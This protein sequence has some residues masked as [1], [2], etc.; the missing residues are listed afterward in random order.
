MIDCFT[1]ESNRAVAEQEVGATAVVGS[2]TPGRAPVMLHFVSRRTP[3]ILRRIDTVV[4]WNNRRRVSSTAIE[5]VKT[6]PRA[7]VIVRIREDLTNKDGIGQ[8]VLNHCHIHNGAR[9]VENAAQIVRVD[10]IAVIRAPS[11]THPIDPAA[12]SRILRLTPTGIRLKTARS[13]GTLRPGAAN[14]VHH[15]RFGIKVVAWATIR[16]DGILVWNHAGIVGPSSDSK[17]FAYRVVVTIWSWIDLSEQVVLLD[18]RQS[19]DQP[20]SMIAAPVAVVRG[21]QPTELTA[22]REPIIGVMV[23]VQ[24]QPDLLQVVRALHTP[25]RFTN[26]LDRWQQQSNQNCND[27]DDYQEFDEGEPA[28][29]SITPTDRENGEKHLSTQVGTRDL[30]QLS[31]RIH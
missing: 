2:E 7:Y 12:Q 23:I 8:P 18:K 10:R 3:V 25:R 6:I 11:I 19:V 1:D 17:P 26:L 15:W 22:W 20:C 30:R 4:D 9:T 29:A 21:P 5:V 27:G 24:R 28:A 31:S 16:F 14:V 13:G